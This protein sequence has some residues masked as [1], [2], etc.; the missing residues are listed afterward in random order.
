[1]YNETSETDLRSLNSAPLRKSRCLEYGENLSNEMVSDAFL[2]L[3]KEQRSA[4][5][6]EAKEGK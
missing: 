2:S 3:Y 1:M 6:S 5:S 4:D